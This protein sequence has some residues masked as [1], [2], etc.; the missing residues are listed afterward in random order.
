MIDSDIV[1]EDID[2]LTG[3]DVDDVDGDGDGWPQYALALQITPCQPLASFDLT[4]TLTLTLTR[5]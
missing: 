3:G 4:L 1:S 2:E 5:P